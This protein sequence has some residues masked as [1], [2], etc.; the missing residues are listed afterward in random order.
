MSENTNNKSLQNMGYDTKQDI[1]GHC[2]RTLAYSA[3][4]E[5]SLWS[6]DD[7]ELQE[8]N[9]IRTAYTHNDLTQQ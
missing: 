1:C 9:S 4:I 2:F 6:E 5:S 3:L 7:V 8:S